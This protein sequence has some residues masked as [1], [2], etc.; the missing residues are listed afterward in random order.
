MSGGWAA[1]SGVAA[2][3]LILWERIGRRFTWFMLCRTLPYVSDQSMRVVVRPVGRVKRCWLWFLSLLWPRQYR[4]FANELVGR[5][6]GFPQAVTDFPFDPEP[7]FMEAQLYL[8]N[9]KQRRQRRRAIHAHRVGCFNRRIK[10]DNGCGTLYGDTHPGFVTSEPLNGWTCT[11]HKC[12]HRERHYCG[13][14]ESGWSDEPKVD[15]ETALSPNS[16][17]CS[18]QQAQ[19]PV[20]VL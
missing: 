13:K 1:W 14:C 9:R 20:D 18:P 2:L 4:V 7:V 5:Y 16:V 6:C 12:S 8:N 19:Y 15:G 10:C 11:S 17:P 3:V